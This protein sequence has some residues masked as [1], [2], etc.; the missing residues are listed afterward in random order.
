MLCPRK[1]ILI[2]KNKDYYRWRGEDETCMIMDVSLHAR[3]VVSITLHSKDDI[4]KQEV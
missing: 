1:C 4:A 3:A 2:C